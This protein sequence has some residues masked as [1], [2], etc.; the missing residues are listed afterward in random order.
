MLVGGCGEQGAVARGWW[1]V[2][3]HCGSAPSISRAKQKQG[4]HESLWS[5]MKAAA[6]QK[7]PPVVRRH[8]AGVAGK[9]SGK[10]ASPVPGVAQPQGGGLGTLAKHFSCGSAPLQSICPGWACSA[11]GSIPASPSP[12]LLS[13]GRASNPEGTV[14]AGG[15]LGDRGWGERPGLVHPKGQLTPWGQG[16][17][18]PQHPTGSP[19]SLQHPGLLLPGGNL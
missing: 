3:G 14:A 1:E 17:A 15:V 5:Y 7:Y 8:G 4:K 13:C 10:E 2:D 16:C 12:A 6:F 9:R 19:G 18:R 11:R